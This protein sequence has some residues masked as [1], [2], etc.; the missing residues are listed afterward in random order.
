[1]AKRRRGKV[2]K[3]LPGAESVTVTNP[4][5]SGIKPAD[6]AHASTVQA[7]DSKKAATQSDAG[8]GDGGPRSTVPPS[9]PV[10]LSP[11]LSERYEVIK[12]LGEGGMGAVYQARDKRLNRDVAL[13]I[14]RADRRAVDE[15][16][17]REARAQASLEHPNACKVYEMGVDGDSR[18]IVMQLIPGVSLDK[19]ASQLNIEQKAKVVRQIAEALHSVHRMGL[20][21]RD[22]K[23]S[24]IM[25]EEGEQGDY[26]AYLMDFGLAREMG[27]EGHTVTGVVA[28]TPAFMAPEQAR[29]EIRK[30]DRRT[31]VYSLG[32]TMYSLF[33]GKPPFEAESLWG[34]L[35]KISVEEPKPLRKL[36][37]SIPIDLDAIV[38]KCLEKE[39]QHRYD[40]AKALGEDLQR[41]LD[42]EPVKARDASIVYVLYKK[43]RK[44]KIRVG[45]GVIVIAVA[46][47]FAGMWIRQQRISTLQATL[48]R[49]LGED[50]KEMEF[51]LRVAYMLPTQDVTG[52]RKKVEEALHKIESRIPGL[53][54]IER[55]PSEYA[56]GRGY[57]ALQNYEAAIEH[58]E[59][60][61]MAGYDIPERSYALGNAQ[62]ELYKQNL[63]DARKIVNE[64]ERKV[65][66]AEID[67][68]YK[69]PAL[70][71]L[72]RARGARLESNELLE[73]LIELYSEN[74]MAAIAKALEAFAKAPYLYEAKKVEGD[75]H[76]AIGMAASAAGTEPS[77]EAMAREF[78][79]ASNAYDV[80][81]DTARSDPNVRN[82]DCELRIQILMKT[83]IYG[84][85]TEKPADDAYKSCDLAMKVGSNSSKGGAQWAFVSVVNAW[86][87]LN[88]GTTATEE[89]RL[90]QEAKERVLAYRTKYPGDK[91]GDYLQ[92]AVLRVEAFFKGDMG[93]DN[94]ADLRE[95][96]DAYDRAIGKD[97]QFAWALNERCSAR[98][99]LLHVSRRL[100]EDSP[101][102]AA[103]VQAL[104]D[105][106]IKQDPDTDMTK[107][108]K[109]SSLISH[110]QYLIDT[111]QSPEKSIREALSGIAA[112]EAEKPSMPGPRIFQVLA[113]H[114]QAYGERMA[115]TDPRRTLDEAQA[116]IDTI[117]RMAPDLK[118][119]YELVVL[120]DTERAE[121]AL[122]RGSNPGPY[123][124]EALEALKSARE[125]KPFYLE[126][127]IMQ[128]RLDIVRLSWLMRSEPI[129]E[130]SFAE[131]EER[132][133]LFLDGSRFEPRLYFWTAS[134]QALRAE[135]LL[136]RQQKD[137]EEAVRIALDRL[138]QALKN[139]PHMADALLL[140]GRLLSMRARVQ[141]DPQERKVSAVQAQDAL[142]RA[143][144]INGFLKKR[145]SKELLLLK[146]IL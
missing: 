2:E 105:E 32:A 143:A 74:Y 16:L 63:D 57:L 78:G 19:I 50:I 46:A 24:N 17:F 141:T 103:E 145:V 35:E 102:G 144:E 83:G 10:T 47:V 89:Q 109:M 127:D 104:C 31:D 6:P 81:I 146:R 124:Q 142:V 138:E 121:D 58:L 119:P 114:T 88:T 108:V 77:R 85:S 106:A 36:E 122:R 38:L 62:G 70:L 65:R 25:V 33:L 49:Q 34:L 42:G 131:V 69:Q 41:F 12:K 101:E 39:P 51:S 27:A 37:P 59:R 87:H 113:L 134:L 43:V 28:G 64:E 129:G 3:R 128:T 92:A 11:A 123:I 107:T 66:L 120:V 90:I 1:M 30:L 60:A 68:K 22:I 116:H 100:S 44:H 135:W 98:D 54:D 13:K 97:K 73:A 110:A 4:S 53:N 45:I 91:F 111:G 112:L 96:I 95:A 61:K 133:K 130:E 99:L 7:P 14:L 117:K 82:A 118:D 5:V 40:S 137:P 52:Q 48:S 9:A 72:K 71:N 8:V 140:K 76:F 84:D 23:P 93:L 126:L 21:H 15:K 86:V 94:R 139:H 80:A 55:G 56:V 79:A 29:G 26:K 18:Y 125:A 20:V 132:L 67:A 136:S 75:A 115:G